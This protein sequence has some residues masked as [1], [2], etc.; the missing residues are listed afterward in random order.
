MSLVT[1]AAV[2]LLMRRG[3]SEISFA[4]LCAKLFSVLAVPT[5][6][7]DAVIKPAERI[8]KHT[9]CCSDPRNHHAASGIYGKFRRVGREAE[10]RMRLNF[11]NVHCDI[12]MSLI[13]FKLDFEFEIFCM[14][15]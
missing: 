1:T 6:R 11:R 12:N 13:S 14:N 10:V 5:V 2:E 7:G 8:W 3:A 15:I 9:G 4:T